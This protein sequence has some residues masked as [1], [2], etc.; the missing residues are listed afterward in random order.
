MSRELKM[1]AGILLVV[2][3]SV[4]Y[5]GI[6]LL[7]MLTGNVPG[8]SAISS[9]K[10]CGAPGMHMRVSTLSSCW[11]RFAMLTRPCFARFGN[12]LP[13]RAHRSLQF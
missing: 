8:Y 12:G 3:P 1:F 5:G 2:L 11:F 13:E 9:D 7:R 4:M 6:T 10:T